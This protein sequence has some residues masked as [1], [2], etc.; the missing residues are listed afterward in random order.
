MPK[1]NNEYQSVNGENGLKQCLL[2]EFLNDVI[3]RWQLHLA[4]LAVNNSNMARILLQPSVDIGAKLTNNIEWRWVMVIKW[5]V[6]NTSMEF[7][8][9]IRALGTPTI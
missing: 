4:C 6:L 7:G 1:I 8:L 9:V 3:K 2:N 5:K